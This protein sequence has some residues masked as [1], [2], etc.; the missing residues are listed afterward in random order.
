MRN[1][2]K[3]MDDGGA[4]KLIADKFIHAGVP[5]PNPPTAGDSGGTT[6]YGQVSNL[7]LQEGDKS[8]E[9]DYK[10]ESQ[11]NLIK[12][13]EYLAR[14]VFKPATTQEIMEALALTKSKAHWTLHNLKIGGW[15]EQA[16]S[17][18][19]LSPE[20]V[21]IADSVRATLKEVMHKYL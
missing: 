18:W 3:L 14:D 13:V 10:N 11:Q 19:R 8:R 16:S 20:L 1:R 6:Q 15:V 5:P 21:K 2:D 12:I 4:I 17:G 9:R 7:P